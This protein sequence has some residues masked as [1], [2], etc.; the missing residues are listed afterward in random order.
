MAP[1]PSYNDLVFQLGDLAR[2]RLANK[3]QAPRSMDRVF[4]AEDGVV[5]LREELA[6]LEHEM[7]DTDQSYREL[8]E[9]RAAERKNLAVVVK[10]H[11]K[12]VDGVSSHTKDLRKQLSSRRAA[13][14]Y[15]R[16][17]LR[18]VEKKHRDLEL[19]SHDERKVG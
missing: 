18:G 15:D 4:R 5:R 10:R 19:S 14:S 13:L 3:P 1:A 12:A 11:Q 9:V 17:S 16:K 8:L 2:E 6:A 7:N